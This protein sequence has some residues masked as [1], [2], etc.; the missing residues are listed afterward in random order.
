MELT[1]TNIW[2]PYP[3]QHTYTQNGIAFHGPRSI[4]SF[5]VPYPSFHT[6][7]H[8]DPIFMAAHNIPPPHPICSQ[9][10]IFHY[11]KYWCNDYPFAWNHH[12][13]TERK[14]CYNKGD[15]HN[16]WWQAASGD[17][18]TSSP[19]TGQGSMSAV[20]RASCIQTPFPIAWV[21]RNDPT[22]D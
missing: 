4:Y 11:C 9:T 3:L 7:K 13:L 6:N 21:K 5:K 19:P 22:S 10:Q 12:T 17:C 18:P 16:N 20:P 8:S 1:F 15:T 14:N 2:A